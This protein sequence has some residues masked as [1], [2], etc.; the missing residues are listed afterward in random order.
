M[1]FRSISQSSADELAQL[2]QS[3][4]QWSLLPL[5]HYHEEIVTKLGNS[6]EPA[7]V[8]YLA[9]HVLDKAAPVRR[10]A[11]LSISRLLSLV[12]TARF[13]EFDAAIR[14]HGDGWHYLPGPWR[15]LSPA[16]AGTFTKEEDMGVLA[17]A[18]MHCNGR[19]R[20]AALRVLA[21]RE[22]GQELP[23]LLLR[24]NDWVVPIREKVR[25]W[26]ATRLRPAYAS[27]FL[28]CLPL[29]LQ[30]ERCGRTQHRWLTEAVGQLVTRPECRPVLQK[31]LESKERDVR[32]ACLRF[33]LAAGVPDAKAASFSALSDPDPLTRLVAARGL[34]PTVEGNERAD[35]YHRLDRDPLMPI[36]RE[37]LYARIKHPDAQ[38]SQALQ[39]ALLDRHSSIRELA[40]FH[41]KHFDVAGFYR[42]FIPTATGSRLVAAICGLGESGTAVD[43][44][45]VRSFLGSDWVRLRKASVF[46]MGRLAPRS[47][48]AELLHALGDASPGVSAVALAAIRPIIA[49]LD[50]RKIGAFIAR[51]YPAFVRRNAVC[52]ISRLKKW[53]QIPLLLSTCRDP[54]ERVSLRA[55]AGV[56]KW[57][58][59]YNRSYA[60][61][62]AEQI[63][64]AT[65]ELRQSQEFLDAYRV[66]ELEA[67]FKQWTK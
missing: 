1:D 50:A 57:L 12:P 37:A 39:A 10:A 26:I 48:E 59:R 54:V 55:V 3:S 6:K 9:P 24:A 67:I 56:R 65:R 11:K 4:A 2:N 13:M 7:L 58:D 53:E 28:R 62:S 33:I 64:H 30:L 49:T 27:Q 38:L 15:L 44:D 66:R 8:P 32:R 20:E 14:E 25:D 35:L 40:R 16:V 43:A 63:D 17:L 21:T 46:S 19:V 42:D 22:D 51:T 60:A 31:G 41:L 47:F 23:F 61:P 18:S 34:L 5:S 52:L 29:V 45:V 36:R